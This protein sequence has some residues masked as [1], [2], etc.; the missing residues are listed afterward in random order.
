ME[1]EYMAASDATSE[2][3]WLRALL[4]EL[5]IKQTEPTVLY[6]DSQSAIAAANREVPH[7]RTKHIDIRYHWVREVIER[8][9]IT[10]D[11]LETAR[12]PAD[13]FTKA[14][15]RARLNA[16]IETFGRDPKD[17]AYT[18]YIMR[19]TLGSLYVG[20]SFSPH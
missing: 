20:R 19:A 12:M 3:V 17:P 16:L 5:G 6:T 7:A 18:D 8:G 11:Y 2:I 14:L 10:L 9:D 1:A 13:A 15:A 4:T